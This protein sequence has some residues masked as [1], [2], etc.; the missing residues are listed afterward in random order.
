MRNQKFIKN[1]RSVDF[2][3]MTML[4]LSP[5][6]C[7]PDQI[8]VPVEST[9]EGRRLAE[10]VCAA[11]ETC[12]CAD[13]RFTSVEACRAEI[14]ANVDSAIANGVTVDNDCFESV[15]TSELMLECRAGPPTV[16]GYVGCLMGRGG[17]DE[18]ESCTVYNFAVDRVS[19]C[20]DGLRCW[21]GTCASTFGAFPPLESGDSC[22]R[23]KGC[24]TFD[25]YCGKKDLRCHP[26]R[27]LGEECND[28]AGCEIFS[29]CKGLGEGGVGICTSREDPESA[30]GVK[31][32][33]PCDS[34]DTSGEFYWCEPATCTCAADPVCVC[35]LTHPAGA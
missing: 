15:L 1:V 34:P 32:W 35:Q 27:G 23:D 2:L 13:G 16:E 24:G 10:A 9:Q 12:G 20:K 22:H 30:C 28:Y 4:L 7:G 25:L 3:L 18:G 33:G 19:D 17:K 5:S 31:D 21:G 29:Y 8:V 11:R 26:T 6:A 14:A